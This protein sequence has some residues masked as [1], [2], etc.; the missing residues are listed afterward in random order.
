MDHHAFRQAVVLLSG[1]HALEILKVLRDGSW[2]LSSEV[3]RTLDIHVTTASKFLQRIAELRLAEVRPHDGRTFEYR[4]GSSRL[5]L[6]VDLADEAGPLREAVDFY[7]TYFHTLF[8]RIRRLG[9]PS[10]EAE[11]QH[12]LTADHQE[13]RSAI[14]E[15]MITGS[16][17]G[18]DR[19]RELVASLHRDIWSV[20]SQTLGSSTAERVFQTALR[21]AVDVYPEL[22]VRCGLTRP[23]GA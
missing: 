10:V 11:M 21:E 22:A 14:F 18:L 20:C 9:W 4:L 3:A 23:L 6:E 5:S 12:R 7:V 8:D 13:L 2:H 16:E 19:L 1:D 17:G 15:E